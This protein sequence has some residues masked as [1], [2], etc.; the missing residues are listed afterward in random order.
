MS[1]SSGPPWSRRRFLAATALGALAG[2]RPGRAAAAPPGDLSDDSLRW[3]A[4]PPDGFVPW[5]APGRVARARARGAFD[6]IMQPN[7]L[8]PRPDVARRLLERAMT[9]LT[10]ATN[11]VAAMRRFIHPADVVAIKPN[12]IAGEKGQ[13][14]A[15]NFELILPVVEAV[16]AVGVPPERITV[17]E[18]YPTYLSGTRVGVGAWQLPPGVRTHWHGNTRCSMPKTKVYRGVETRYVTALTDATAVIAMT[19]IKDHSLT[20]YTGALKNVTHGS[21]DNPQ[22]HHGHMASPQIAV[23][24]RHPI[25]TSRLRLHLVDGFKLIYDKGPLDRDPRTRVAHGAV[26]ASSDPVALDALGWALVDRE[27][28]E[29]GLKSLKDA[30]REPRYIHTA[31]ELGLGISDAAALRLLDAE[32]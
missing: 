13:T 24:Y 14:M 8:W 26:Y 18:Q 6:Q 2:A 4:S 9:D 31:A 30:K 22:D 25:V 1:T 17:Y 12:G 19:L 15:V 10:G 32:I 5:S 21:I 11:L 28:V 23:L 27:R 29:R 3:I 16:L 7:L 20:G